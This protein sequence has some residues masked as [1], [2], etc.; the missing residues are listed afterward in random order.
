LKIESLVKFLELIKGLKGNIDLYEIS[1][2]K[3][4]TLLDFQCDFPPYEI[5]YTSE[6]VMGCLYD[7]TKKV[8][9][10]VDEIYMGED[11]SAITNSYC[12]GENGKILANP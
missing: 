11:G 9:S 1:E 2:Y 10:L 4:K 12:I 5:T 8:L 3:G 6:D 7:E